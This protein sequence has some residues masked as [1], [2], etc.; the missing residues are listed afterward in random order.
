MTDPPPDFAHFGNGVFCPQEHARAVHGHDPL[1]VRQGGILDQ[2]VDAADAGVV[3]QDVQLVK[4]RRGDGDGLLPAALAGHVE[5]NV[6]ARTAG[7]VD[8]RF[9]AAALVVQNIANGDLGPLAAKHPGLR[10]AHAAGA[11]TNEC[12]L[13]VQSAQ[14]EPS[15]KMLLTTP[16]RFSAQPCSSAT[17]VASRLEPFSTTSTSTA[18]PSLMLSKAS[19]TT[20]WRRK[21]ISS[22]PPM[23]T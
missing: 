10:C 1:P 6:N 20:T 21:W 22:S 8:F 16:F 2:A 5:V 18:V 7:C 23:S 13:A 17:R 4:A 3:D 14:C 15:V 19:P 11:A 9:H 12:H